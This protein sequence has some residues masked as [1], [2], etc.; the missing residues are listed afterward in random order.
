MLFFVNN[1]YSPTQTLSNLYDCTRG[2]WSGVSESK[3]NEKRIALS[4]YDGVILEVFS[5]EA[6]FAAGT[7]L[8]SRLMDDYTNRFEFVGNVMHNHPYKGK[9]LI[10]ENGEKYPANQQGYGYIN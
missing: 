10:K 5:I 6:W 9:R 7:T 4:I 3:R 2:F 8:S 1:S